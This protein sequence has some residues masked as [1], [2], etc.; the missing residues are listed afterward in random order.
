MQLTYAQ[1]G[2]VG[3]RGV[4]STGRISG[5]RSEFQ[6]LFGEHLL[7]EYTHDL[8]FLSHLPEIHHVTALA[9]PPQPVAKLI[10]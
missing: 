2:S 8:N 5:E 1:D 6:M 3:A 10:A 7:V 4:V 9:Y